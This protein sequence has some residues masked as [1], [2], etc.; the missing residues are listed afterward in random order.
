M[1][2]GNR[3]T[4]ARRGSLWTGAKGGG[5]GEMFVPTPIELGL[6]IGTQFEFRFPLLICQAFPESH[7]DLCAFVGRQL[8]EVR[9]IA[10]RH[11]G[12]LSRCRRRHKGTDGPRAPS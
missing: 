5:V 7:R 10:R 3:R 9:E 6:L 11:V 1:P 4:T 12:I 8:Q 2:Y